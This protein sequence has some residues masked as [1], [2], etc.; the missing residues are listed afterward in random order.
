MHESNEDEGSGLFTGIV[1]AATAAAGVISALK[2]DKAD[3]KTPP[4]TARTIAADS[5]L[6]VPLV[7]WLG[8]AVAAV[9]GLVLILRGK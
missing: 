4:R 8:I 5:T 6:G 1:S 7:A 9:L 2:S 3:T